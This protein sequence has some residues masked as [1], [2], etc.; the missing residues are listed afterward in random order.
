LLGETNTKIGRYDGLSEGIPNP[1]N[2]AFAI[3]KKEIEL[4]SKIEGAQSI[5]SGVLEYETG[6]N[7]K[8]RY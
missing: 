3:S 5:M 8:K 6:G 2:I 7:I 4:F 1:E